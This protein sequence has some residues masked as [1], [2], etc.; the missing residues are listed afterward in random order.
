VGRDVVCWFDLWEEIGIEGWE[1]GG[2]N[3]SLSTKIVCKCDV[4]KCLF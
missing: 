4:F 3:D 1:V 2:V